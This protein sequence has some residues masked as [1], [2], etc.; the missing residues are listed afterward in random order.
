[1]PD[2]FAALCGIPRFAHRIHRLPGAVRRAGLEKVVRESVPAERLLI[3]RD[4]I[5]G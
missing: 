2:H 4:V 5:F 3:R 1:M